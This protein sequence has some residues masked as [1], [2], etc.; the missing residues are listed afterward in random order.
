[1]NYYLVYD[2]GSNSFKATLFSQSKDENIKMLEHNVFFLDIWKYIK[3]D[4]IAPMGIKKITTFLKSQSNSFAQKYKNLSQVAFATQFF[5]QLKNKEVILNLKKQ[6]PLRNFE[7]ISEELEA[8]LS[9]YAYQIQNELDQNKKY[10]FIDLGGGSC[11]F[12]LTYLGKKY[13]YSS[14]KIA[15]RSL[16]KFPLVDRIKIITQELNAI[17]K[18]FH[19]KIPTFMND[20]EKINCIGTGGSLSS[21]LQIQKSMH[22]ANGQLSFLQLENLWVYTKD[23]NPDDFLEF[24]FFEPERKYVI[25]NAIVTFYLLLKLFSLSKIELSSDTISAGYLFY[26]LNQNKLKESL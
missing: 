18:Y 24:K 26:L 23:F 25:K 15:V 2:L 1:M 4:I 14:N 6:L 19:T 9:W 3:N 12:L 7:V 11:E 5:R 17:Q 8:N 13:F 22:S 20:S 16:N 21:T 10:L